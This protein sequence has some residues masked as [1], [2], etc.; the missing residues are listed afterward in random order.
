[1]KKL[2]NMSIVKMLLSQFIALVLN[3]SSFMVLHFIL[4]LFGRSLVNI[5]FGND[6]ILIIWVVFTGSIC[7]YL[8]MI[9]TVLIVERYN[10]YNK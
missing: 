8:G 2:I 3:V 5:V 9:W 6:A 4:R 10:T 1:M 7:L